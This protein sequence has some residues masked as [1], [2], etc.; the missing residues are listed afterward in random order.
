MSQPFEGCHILSIDQTIETIF[1]LFLKEPFEKL[2]ECEG[3]RLTHPQNHP[4]LPRFYT[5][6]T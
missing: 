1:K 3:H 6:K 4:L 2:R 5:Q